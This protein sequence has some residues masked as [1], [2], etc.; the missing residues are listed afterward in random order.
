MT[1]QG[2]LLFPAGD[3]T[4]FQLAAVPRMSEV[5]QANGAGFGEFRLNAGAFWTSFV[6][7]GTEHTLAVYP[8]DIN[9]LTD[10]NLYENYLRWEFESPQVRID[11]F[12]RRLTRLIREGEWELPEEERPSWLRRVIAS[13]V[14]RS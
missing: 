10:Q 13:L 9:I 6:I 11:A 1:E 2:D 14:R 3:P 5:L 8:Q 12:A 7:H 4:P